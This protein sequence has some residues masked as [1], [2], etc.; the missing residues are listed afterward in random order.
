MPE[1]GT[2]RSNEHC[3]QRDYH[4]CHTISF[5]LACKRHNRDMETTIVQMIDEA[6]THGHPVMTVYEIQGAIREMFCERL[7]V[8]D[9]M[10]E[11][12]KTPMFERYGWRAYALNRAKRGDWLADCFD[13]P[14]ALPENQND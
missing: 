2:G 9:I 11:L 13:L 10:E 5:C 14:L 4:S 12:E 3:V 6:M 8:D 7:S 1:A